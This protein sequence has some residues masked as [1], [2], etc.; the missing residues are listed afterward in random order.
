VAFQVRNSLDDHELRVR[1]CTKIWTCIARRHIQFCTEYDRV[2]MTL[3]STSNAGGLSPRAVNPIY[4]TSA[5]DNKVSSWLMYSIILGE[6]EWKKAAARAKL[7]H[8][9]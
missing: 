5:S 8:V 9:R 2:E 3:K 6:D 1:F 4:S 7:A